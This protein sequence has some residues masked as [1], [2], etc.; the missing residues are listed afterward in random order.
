MNKVGITVHFLT[1]MASFLILKCFEFIK[2]TITNEMTQ[3]S[4]VVASIA[5]Y[6][7]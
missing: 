7:N 5:R 3:L 1:T 2:K 6:H 4:L